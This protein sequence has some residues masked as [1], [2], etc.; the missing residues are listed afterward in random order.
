MSC[1]RS[2]RKHVS[3]LV[4]INVKAVMT[5]LSRLF[6]HRCEADELHQ[7]FEMNTDCY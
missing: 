5:E 3:T 1:V 7:C 4:K 6:L 2:K